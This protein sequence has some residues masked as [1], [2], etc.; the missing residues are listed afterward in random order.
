M[1]VTPRPDAPAPQPFVSRGR[2]TSLQRSEA[3]K[4]ERRR[5]VGSL[6]PSGWLHGRSIRQR[7]GRHDRRRTVHCP[8]L[9][10]RSPVA[11]RRDDCRVTP[12]SPPP[13]HRAVLN[14][15]QRGSSHSSLRPRPAGAGSGP[16]GASGQS[17]SHRARSSRDQLDGRRWACVLRAD[18]STGTGTCSPAGP[19][20]GVACEG[21]QPMNCAAARLRRVVR[22]A[23]SGCN[24]AASE[25]DSS[26][27][28]LAR[29]ATASAL[30]IGGPRAGRAGLPAPLPAPGPPAADARP[31]CHAPAP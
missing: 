23:I 28:A 5:S 20:P 15:A 17:R 1:G 29:S 31:S 16:L 27:A 30:S 3:T 25:E 6:K 2:S 19:T 18:T 22:L 21:S 14:T 11:V 9:D 26:R 8:E 13:L 7:W 10:T 12:P 4:K 24:A